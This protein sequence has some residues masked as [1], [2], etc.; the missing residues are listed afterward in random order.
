[1]HRLCRTKYIN[2][3]SISADRKRKLTGDYSNTT[4]KVTL[5]SEDGFDYKINCLFCGNSVT[6]RQKRDRDAYQVMSKH[7]EF[8]K[9]VLEIC[10]IRTD[11][12]SQIVKGR[13]SFVSDL[14]AEDAVYHTKCSQYF[15]LGKPLPKEYTSKTS[16]CSNKR[17]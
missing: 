17:G 1:M 11:Q 8:D 6:N 15:R 16:E 3:N 14:Y 4:P 5:R 7:R 9:S 13:V 12:L 10:K 2:E